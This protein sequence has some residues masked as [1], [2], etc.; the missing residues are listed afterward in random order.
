MQLGPGSRMRLLFAA[1]Y[2]DGQ[3]SLFSASSY[4]SFYE[5]L[6]RAFSNNRGLLANQAASSTPSSLNCAR[7]EALK[8]RIHD[9]ESGSTHSTAE[10]NRLESHYKACVAELEKQ[11]GDLQFRLQTVTESKA[12]IQKTLEELRR[13]M[14]EKEAQLTDVVSELERLKLVNVQQQQQQQQPLSSSATDAEN[15]QSTTVVPPKKEEDEEEKQRLDEEAI[16]NSELYQKLQ[17]L[18]TSLQ[19]EA[20]EAGQRVTETEERLAEVESRLQ[21]QAQ[22]L[23]TANSE[24]AALSRAYLSAE[25]IL[26]DV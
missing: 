16:V 7:C 14:T 10:R 17:A 12:E 13:Q 23:A 15:Q 21:D 1:T 18:C 8:E 6:I 24:R 26:L 22:V 5:A 25:T 4:W 9:L 3:Q 11:N 2:L 20:V 19:R